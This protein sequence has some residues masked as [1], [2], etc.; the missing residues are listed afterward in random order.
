MTPRKAVKER[1]GPPRVWETTVLVR[2][3][4]D[5]LAKLDAV[6]GDGETRSDVIRS[7]LEREAERRGAQ[8]S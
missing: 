4:W 2:V 1:T 5:L 7:A 6:V 3:T 8:A